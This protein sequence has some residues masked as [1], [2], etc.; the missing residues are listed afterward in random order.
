MSARVKWA[1]GGEA[2]ILSIASDAIMLR[3]TVPSP[4][5]SRIEGTVQMQGEGTANGWAMPLRVKV[6]ACRREAD[7][8]YVVKGR[9]MDMARQARERLKALVEP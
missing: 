1:N 3:S 5:G 8:E 4:P 2:R 6:H 9:P 7:G